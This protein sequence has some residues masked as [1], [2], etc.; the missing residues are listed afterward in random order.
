MRAKRKRDAPSEIHRREKNYAQQKYIYIFFRDLTSRNLISLVIFPF[1]FVCLILFMAAFMIHHVVSCRC[2]TIDRLLAIETNFQFMKSN[3]SNDSQKHLV[4][5]KKTL[6]MNAWKT[7][8][9][10]LRRTQQIFWSNC[11]KP[12]ALIS[13]LLSSFLL[14]CF[15]L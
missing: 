7:T 8:S 9:N 13:T 14:H 3:K 10:K 1:F 12:F 2:R 5:T 11:Y 4:N 6:K 15:N